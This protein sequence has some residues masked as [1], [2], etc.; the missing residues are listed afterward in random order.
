MSLQGMPTDSSHVIRDVE[1]VINLLT[2]HKNKWPQIE[3]VLKHLETCRTLL[4]ASVT[5]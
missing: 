3:R 4:L 5:R 2:K 1:W